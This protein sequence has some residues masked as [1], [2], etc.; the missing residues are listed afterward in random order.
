MSVGLGERL[1]A[2][3]L[4]WVRDTGVGVGLSERHRRERWIG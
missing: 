3:A 2:R 1:G 4:G